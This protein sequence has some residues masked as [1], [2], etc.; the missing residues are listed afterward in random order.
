MPLLLE[1]YQVFDP[2][3]DYERHESQEALIRLQEPTTSLRRWVEP[4]LD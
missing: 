1:R 2:A 4:H 3:G